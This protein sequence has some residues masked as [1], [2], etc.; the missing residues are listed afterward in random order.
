VNL[1][2]LF[3]EAEVS[4]SEARAEF[5]Y[6]SRRVDYWRS[7]VEGLRGLIAM[8]SPPVEKAS[9]AIVAAE[10]LPDLLDHI[11]VPLTDNK[12]AT[13]PVSE[14]IMRVMLTDREAI[15][16]LNDLVHDI[17]SRGWLN[18]DLKHPK[19]GVRA[20]AERMV[21]ENGTL[22]K[23]GAGR[24]RLVKVP[25]SVL[26]ADAAERRQQQETQEVTSR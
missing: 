2:Q 23:T 19:E 16:H 4:L 12:Q 20:A 17:E 26:L 3:K 24:Y 6:A 1:N 7:V 14:A 18:S 5:Q 8:E 10:N 21:R 9:A 22:E 13:P 15:W 11:V 25:S